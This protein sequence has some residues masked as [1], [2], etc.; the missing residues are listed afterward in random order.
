MEVAVD[1]EMVDAGC[2]ESEVAAL[3]SGGGGCVGVGLVG[4]AAID[5]GAL[6]GCC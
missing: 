1:C 6:L 3:R 4:R 5:V 2:L